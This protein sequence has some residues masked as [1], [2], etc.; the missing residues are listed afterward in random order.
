PGSVY[1]TVTAAA[2]VEA[3]HVTPNSLVAC[4][5][6][7]EQGGNVFN[8]W[9]PFDEGEMDL[10][11][12]LMRSC[13]TYFYE[14]AYEQWLAEDRQLQAADRDLSQAQID[15]VVPEVARRFGFGRRL[16]IDL[17]SEAA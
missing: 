6:S 4:P 2:Y 11:T 3:G 16:G 10:S 17:P 8:N 14:L 9:N 7:Y 12:A 15:E 13:D 1:K 5:S